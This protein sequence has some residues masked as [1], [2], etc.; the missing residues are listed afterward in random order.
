MKKICILFAIFGLAIN[1]SDL[2]AANTTGNILGQKLIELV[3]DGN[4]GAISPL[5][6]AGANVNAVDNNGSTALMYATYSGDKEA[7]EQL[8]RSGADVNIVSYTGVKA[9]DLTNSPEIKQ[10]LRKRQRQEAC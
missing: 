5:L 3:R 8:L 10:M 6:Q 1:F 4:T 9:I 2:N 7:V